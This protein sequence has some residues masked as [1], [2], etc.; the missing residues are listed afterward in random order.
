MGTSDKTALL[1]ANDDDRGAKQASD[2][3]NTSTHLTTTD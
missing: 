2:K 3:Q 1:N